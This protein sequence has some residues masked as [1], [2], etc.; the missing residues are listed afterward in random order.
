M[1]LTRGLALFPALLLAACGPSASDRTEVAE[2]T[3]LVAARATA[4]AFQGELRDALAAAI[5]AEGAAGAVEACSMIAP[6][7]AA[8]YSDATG[9]VV[10]RTALRVRNPL[11][12][13]DAFERE[14]LEVLTARPMAAEGKPAEFHRIVGGELRYMRALP[15]GGLCLQCHGPAISPDVRAAIEVIYPEDQATGF[16]EGELRGAISIRWPL[17]RGAPPAASEVDLASPSS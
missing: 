4:D 17:Q 13:A 8:R 2:E 7:L 16:A 9:A 14:G 6:E 3:A 12:E 15:T 5:E 1:A 11:S 10:R